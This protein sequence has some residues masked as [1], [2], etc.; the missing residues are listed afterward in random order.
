MLGCGTGPCR[1]A[2]PP[3]SPPPCTPVQ[4]PLPLLQDFFVLGARLAAAADAAAGA[5]HDLRGW[6]D[7]QGSAAAGSAR[8]GPR[9]SSPAFPIP[10]SPLLARRPTSMKWYSFCPSCTALSS[11]LAL[12]AWRAGA[13]AGG[14]RPARH[15][16]PAHRLLWSRCSGTAGGPPIGAANQAG[17]HGVAPWPQRPAHGR[18]AS[19]RAFIPRLVVA[20]A[21]SALKARL[22][23]Y[24]THFN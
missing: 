12:P 9:E 15:R 1:C 19:R 23:T 21:S 13:A 24:G 11:F 4:C 10:R 3:R 7:A 16:G 22:Q 2:P 20:A 14:G 18:Q 6:G 5:R 8:V 17:A